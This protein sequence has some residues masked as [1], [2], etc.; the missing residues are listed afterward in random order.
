VLFLLYKLNID[1]ESAFVVAIRGTIWI[2]GTMRGA[3]I[4][5]A[6]VFIIIGVVFWT[7]IY[8][9]YFSGALENRTVKIPLVLDVCVPFCH[10]GETMG[11]SISH[12]SNDDALAAILFTGGPVLIG[13]L[14]SSLFAILSSGGHWSETRKVAFERGSQNI[15]EP[16]RGRHGTP[17]E[18][19]GNH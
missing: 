2:R 5:V 8:P 11:A 12:G 16:F 1:F 18:R 7:V 13:A 10:T 14:R 15:D 3:V 4:V 6:V 17:S 9:R 19:S